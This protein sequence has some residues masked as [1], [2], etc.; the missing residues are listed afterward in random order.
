MRSRRE[1]CVE[2][3]LASRDRDLNYIVL[4]LQSFD[5]NEPSIQFSLVTK[6]VNFR[7][8]SRRSKVRYFIVDGVVYTSRQAAQEAKESK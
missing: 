4:A 1:D 6:V 3:G 2:E 7:L 8:E 5:P